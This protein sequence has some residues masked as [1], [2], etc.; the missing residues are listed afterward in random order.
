M[1]PSLTPLTILLRIARLK[2]CSAFAS[3]SSPSRLTLICA[4]WTTAEVR[5]GNSKSSLPLGP[6]TSTF[7]SFTSTFTLAGISTGILPMRDINQHRLEGWRGGG[8]ECR[9][10]AIRQHSV[11]PSLQYSVLMFSPDITDHF[12]TQVLFSRI[13]AGHDAARR[14]DDARAHAPE[15][16]RNLG[17]AHV[18]AQPGLAD[19]LQPDDHA[20][21][22][23]VFQLEFQFPGRLALDGAIRDVPFLLE[24][25]GDA[26][27]HFRVR[28][29][30]FRHQREVG[31]A[32]AGQHV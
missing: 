16:A 23:L 5:L 3:A 7:R 25:G 14:R 15:H 26:F 19:P 17:R 18:A 4:P 1:K 6:S 8:M 12:A 13:H 24:N 30:H 29:F 22:P 31:V 9:A 10:A 27:F 28:H 20:L 21:A 2:P 11:I 32:Q